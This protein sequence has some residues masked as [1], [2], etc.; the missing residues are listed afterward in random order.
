MYIYKL[1]TYSY[2]ICRVSLYYLLK[3]NLRKM[4][5]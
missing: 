5:V 2:Y 3:K 1:H 4:Y